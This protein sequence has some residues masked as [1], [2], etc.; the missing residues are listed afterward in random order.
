MVRILLLR[1][2]TPGP[3]PALYRDAS[4]A[5]LDPDVPMPTNKRFFLGN[6]FAYQLLAVGAGSF[7][8][9]CWAL[10]NKLYPVA[11][12]AFFIGAFL[13]Y[14][15]KRKVVDYSVEQGVE[16]YETAIKSFQPQVLV[17]LYKVKS[18]YGL[19]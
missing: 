7:V 9:V 14:K 3:T 4:H 11:L 6:K 15:L 2:F 16:I 18:L 1:G 17:S 5:I 13:L 12:M 10:L 19:I 8:F